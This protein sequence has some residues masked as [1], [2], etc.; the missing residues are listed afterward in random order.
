[1][2]AYDVKIKLASAEK[3]MEI[4]ILQDEAERLGGTE[5]MAREHPNIKNIMH[6]KN[7]YN[8]QDQESDWLVSGD[9]YTLVK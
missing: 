1:M 6:V 4:G 3:L 9:Y 8:N 7:L 5:Q 2:N